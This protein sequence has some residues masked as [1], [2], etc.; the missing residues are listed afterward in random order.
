MTPETGLSARSESGCRHSIGFSFLANAGV[1]MSG[2]RGDPRF[3]PLEEEYQPYI[4]H[5]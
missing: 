4:G 1:L 5:P 2:Q 3:E